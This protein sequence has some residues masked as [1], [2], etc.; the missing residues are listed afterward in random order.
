MYC[1]GTLWYSVLSS[2]KKSVYYNVQRKMVFCSTREI[3]S[4]KFK[5]NLPGRPPV[6]STGS[7]EPIVTPPNSNGRTIPLK[8]Y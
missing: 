4:L 5:K 6:Y 7:Y 3:V 1:I 2:N 8:L